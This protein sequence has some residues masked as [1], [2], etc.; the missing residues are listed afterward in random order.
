MSTEDI[1]L[2]DETPQVTFIK[3][4]GGECPAYGKDVVCVE[5]RD[6][7][8]VTAEAGT[9]AWNH[10]NVNSDVMGWRMVQQTDVAALYDGQGA[11]AVEAAGISLRDILLDSEFLKSLAAGMSYN[12]EC[13]EASTK[14]RLNE[15][16]MRI[17]TADASPFMFKMGQYVMVKNGKPGLVI[18]RAEFHDS[19]PSYLLRMDT[20]GNR[21][22]YN[23]SHMDAIS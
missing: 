13:A 17:E 16:A 12:S 7:T 19:E 20:S 8:R 3:W 21:E 5:Y 14:H 2:F 10:L 23:Q 15:I 1:N 22:A 11:K 4:D 9:I 6:G 18:G